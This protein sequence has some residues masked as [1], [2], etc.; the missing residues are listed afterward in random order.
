[1]LKILA[2]V[3]VSAL[4]MAAGLTV[5]DPIRQRQIRFMVSAGRATFAG[6]IPSICYGKN[7]TSPF[8]LVGHLSAELE[9]A[10][11]GNVPGQLPIRHHA[12]DVQILDNNFCKFAGQIVGKLMQ[13]VGTNVGNSF[14]ES[15]N[16]GLQFSIA[17]TAFDLFHQSPL[18][19]GQL[20]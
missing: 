8:H 2:G 6:W 12:F 4:S 3:V 14:V 7:A 18:I 19:P 16:A 5:V 20:P 15:G 17:G 9:Q 13:R 10:D 11:V 1:M